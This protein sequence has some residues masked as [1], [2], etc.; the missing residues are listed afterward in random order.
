MEKLKVLNKIILTTALIFGAGSAF[1]DHYIIDTK[2]GH[3]AIE[4][5]VSHLG[6]SWN[7]GRFNK[8][9]GEFDYDKDKPEEFKV[10]VEVDTTS[11]DSNHGERDKHL[12]SDK[13]L[14]SSE[15]PK[16]NFVSTSYEAKDEK[17]GIL[18]GD[19]TLH[20]TTKSIQIALEKVGEGED[21][22]GGYRAGFTGTT[23]FT[24]SDFG[25]KNILGPASEN[26]YITLHIEGIKE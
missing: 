9:T 8:F 18:T 25:I 23:K 19:L 13:F 7:V 10:N 14:D 11:V 3:A 1:A 6:Y 16:A 26:I 5:K 4:F 17:T 24:M 15:F 20:G 2:E 21:P 22:W 12:R